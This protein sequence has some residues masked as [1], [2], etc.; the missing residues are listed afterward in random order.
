M[1]PGLERSV[2]ILP[3]YRHL[4]LLR[5]LADM[6]AK[7]R[8]AGI[9]GDLTGNVALNQQ[10]DWLLCQGHQALKSWLEGRISTAF[11]KETIEQS[12]PSLISRMSLML[13]RQVIEE[14]STNER[15]F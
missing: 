13:S 3:S 12:T 10:A 2:A 7:L 4:S 6:R 9:I 8:A 14:M 15:N 1:G 5:S 11:A